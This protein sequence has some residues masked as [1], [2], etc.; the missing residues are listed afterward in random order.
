M[1][2]FVKISY[3]TLSKYDNLSAGDKK[4]DKIEDTSARREEKKSMTMFNRKEEDDTSIYEYDYDCLRNKE[5]LGHSCI[6]HKR[7]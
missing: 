5:L 3:P 7:R 6:E 2:E 1:S 4:R